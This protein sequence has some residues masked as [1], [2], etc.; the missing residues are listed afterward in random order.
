LPSNGAEYEYCGAAV[1]VFASVLRTPLPSGAKYPYVLR[2]ERG[3]VSVAI[4]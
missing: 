3:V 4:V 1:G 2:R